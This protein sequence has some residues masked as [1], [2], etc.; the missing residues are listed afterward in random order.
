M[1]LLNSTGHFGE[2]GEYL[3]VHSEHEHTQRY[4]DDE[5]LKIFDGLQTKNRSP[6][7]GVW[8]VKADIFEF[9]LV[10]RYLKLKQ[11]SL[12]DVKWIWL[13]RR[14]KVKQAISGIRMWTT[15]IAHARNDS[16]K[17]DLQKRY[18]QISISREELAG[19][20]FEKL[21]VDSM[22]E[23]FFRKYQIK[24]YRLDYEDIVDPLTW[25]PLIKR[26]LSFLNVSPIRPYKVSTPLMQIS[27][28]QNLELEKGLASEMHFL[29]KYWPDLFEW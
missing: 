29:G 5:I 15:Q 24:P 11:M 28:D 2:V 25:E 16:E 7:T 17:C 19:Q 3:S 8:G 10:Q 20:V 27:S 4:S 26:I 13:R 21:L 18:D 6:L 22:T 9:D 23:Q 12:H 14:D 1:N